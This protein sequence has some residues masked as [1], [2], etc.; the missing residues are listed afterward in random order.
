[1]L[2]VDKASESWDFGPKDEI[3]ADLVV[4]RQLGGGNR[5]E[6]FEAWDR[7]L[8][9]SVAAK[10]LRPHKVIEE[11]SRVALKREAEIAGRLS[12]PNLIQ[13]VRSSDA[14][15]R[16]HLVFELVPATSVEDH[17]ENVG[18]VRVP[19]TCLLGIVMLAAL[20]YM[21]DEHVLH[22]DV[23]PA[24]VTMGDPPR[25][26]DLSLAR[27]G[28]TMRL[29]REVGTP[30][31]MAPEQCRRETLTPATDLFC[32]GATL[33]EALTAMQAFSLGNDAGVELEARYPQL[34]EEPLPLRELQPEIPRALEEIIMR[35]LA[36]DPA[37]RPGSADECARGLTG[38]LESI[39]LGHLLDD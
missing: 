11:R 39:G 31:Y 19:E 1:M 15:P 6:V 38:V 30:A 35:C 23:K 13:F 12:H 34:V 16:P 8:S 5:Y 25:L 10:V 37:Q 22:L 9:R 27:P 18:P 14:L 3:D 21:H 7:G 33:Y 2:K 36:T 4:I 24:N 28:L 26:L 17:L 29:D 20:Q 32:L